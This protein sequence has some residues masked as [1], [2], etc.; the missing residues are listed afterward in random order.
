[1]AVLP[2]PLGDCACG[3][4]LLLALGPGGQMKLVLR[5]AEPP[6]SETQGYNEPL[7]GRGR[8]F[9][10]LYRTDGFVLFTDQESVAFC[11]SLVQ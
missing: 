5:A 9:H 6:P 7:G 10:A 1:M 3:P 11:N 4:H 2:S 8:N